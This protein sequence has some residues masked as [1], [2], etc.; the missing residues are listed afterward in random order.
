M[1]FIETPEDLYTFIKAHKIAT[2]IVTFVF[3]FLCWLIYEIIHA[4]MMPD[5]YED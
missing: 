3:I 2:G 4:P 5:D 1:P